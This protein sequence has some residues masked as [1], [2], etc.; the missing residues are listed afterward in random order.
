VGILDCLVEDPHNARSVDGEWCEVGLSDEQILERIDKFAPHLIGLSIPFSYQHHM[1]MQLA[2]KIKLAFPEI[3]LVVGGNH[4]SAVPENID[5]RYIDYMIIGEG[6]FAL[7]HLIQAINQ[8]GPWHEVP[9]IISQS[10]LTFHRTA[11][12]EHL[13]D[14]PFPAIDLLPLQKL[15]GKGRRWINMLATRGCVFDCVFCSIHTIMG[16]K[17]R[18]RSV[19]NVIAEIRHWHRL[20]KIQEIYF[21]DDNLTANR[22]WAKELF[23]RIAENNFGIRFYARNGIRADSIDRELL[24]LMKAAGYKDFYIAPESG[25][26]ET[27]DKIIGK[28][29]KLEDCTRAVKL[30]RE[31]GIQANAFFVLGFPQETLQDIQATIS[32]ARHLKKLGCESFWFSLAAPYPGT[33]LF[34]KCREQG[35]L[36]PDFDY[37][38][39]R[40]A[41]SVIIHPDYSL[42]QLEFIRE[43][44]MAELGQHPQSPLEKARSGLVLFFRDQ[45]YFFSKLKSKL[46]LL[47]SSSLNQRIIHRAAQLLSGEPYHEV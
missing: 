20:Y 10:S 39:L 21:E 23:R 34:E 13:D 19:E 5:R 33:R 32:Y 44:A 46:G 47:N 2:E 4:V 36:V 11:W 3:L 18:R 42:A 41:K 1:A 9:G 6:E 25:S 29:M 28:K 24:V 16:H 43:S 27:L 26:Q 8:G 17:I 22:A 31:V 38:K 40:V 45:S 15:W 37:R 7:L 12:I 30:A 35:H 14:L